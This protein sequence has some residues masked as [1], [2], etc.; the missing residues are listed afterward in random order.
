MVQGRE[1]ILGA[2]PTQSRHNSQI[3]EGQ[4]PLRGLDAGDLKLFNEILPG[5]IE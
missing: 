5:L 2:G 3:L 1:M 4:R